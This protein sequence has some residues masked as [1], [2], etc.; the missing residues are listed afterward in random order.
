MLKGDLIL[1]LAYY[2]NLPL[3]GIL[4]LYE[5]RSLEGSD[6]GTFAT[7]EL[8]QSVIIAI[9]RAF[10]SSAI[11]NEIAI[12]EMIARYYSVFWKE[13]A[14]IRNQLSS[15]VTQNIVLRLFEDEINEVVKKG[16]TL[17][18]LE[19][20]KEMTRLLSNT[21]ARILAAQDEDEIE[22]DWKEIRFDDLYVIEK[23]GET[24]IEEDIRKHNLN[25]QIQILKAIDS[26]T[27]WQAEVV[28]N[29]AAYLKK[30]VKRYIKF[31]K[32]ALEEG[33]DWKLNTSDADDSW[34]IFK[35]A[36]LGVSNT[37]AKRTLK[38]VNGIL[39]EKKTGFHDGM[40]FD[41]YQKVIKQLGELAGNNYVWYGQSEAQQILNELQKATAEPNSKDW[42][43]WIR[44]HS[45]FTFLLQCLYKY[46][47]KA[48]Q[49]ENVVQN[50]RL[51]SNIARKL[52]DAHKEADRQTLENFIDELNKSLEDTIDSE[53][54]D[55]LFS[56]GSMD[57]QRETL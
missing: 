52:P 7:A 27:L 56:L 12:S 49:S 2:K 30:L 41:I 23:Q 47:M 45:Y 11:V 24:K 46:K 42:D 13:F 14:Y 53:E 44:K 5:N 20:K 48:E 38:S 40:P 31:I 8:E 29:V 51:L 35:K 50:A 25:N 55:K 32:E 54:F 39:E 34:K 4:K 21:L 15:S 10:S 1:N 17:E 19:E 33:G 28:G 9:W 3:D 43:T 16:S 18:K 26:R 6:E 57:K 37:I 22:K 36:D